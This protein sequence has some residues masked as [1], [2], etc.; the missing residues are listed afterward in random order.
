VSEDGIGQTPRAH[1]PTVE[2][3]GRFEKRAPFRAAVEELLAAG[4]ERSDLSVLDTH[5]S[6]SASEGGRTAWQETVAGLVG[7]VNYIGPIA[8]AGLIMVAAGPVGAAVSGAIAAG[9]VGIALKEALDE[10]RATPHTETFARA[11]ERGALLLWVRAPSAE[12]QATARDILARHG[13][14]D[15]HTHARVAELEPGD[16]SAAPKP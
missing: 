3:V 15:V 10:V 1:G 12:R 7:E 16:A 9:L 13:A 4:F 14:A 8:T 5:E 6:L 2:V 11:L